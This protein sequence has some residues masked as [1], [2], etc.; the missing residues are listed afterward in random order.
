MVAL[1][2]GE[3]IAAGA[4]DEAVENLLG[5]DD[6]HGGG[7]VIV[8]GADADILSAFGLEGDALADDGDDI[9]RIADA[10]DIIVWL[11]G[12]QAHAIN[13]PP[14]VFDEVKIRLLILYLAWPWLGVVCAAGG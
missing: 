7:V 11:W 3:D 5:G 14:V 1:D 12:V 6:A 10:L 4:A 2:E 9:R 13:S 8:E